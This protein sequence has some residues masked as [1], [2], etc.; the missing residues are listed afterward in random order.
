MSWVLADVDSTYDNLCRLHAVRDFLMYSASPSTTM[1]TFSSSRLFFASSSPRSD[2]SFVVDSSSIPSNS[3]GSSMWD[4][5]VGDLFNDAL[6]NAFPL[7]SARS[8]LQFLS[9][10]AEL[11][12]QHSAQQYVRNLIRARDT[13]LVTSESNPSGDI[14]TLSTLLRNVEISLIIISNCV[15]SS[16]W[17]PV[18]VMTRLASFDPRA[19]SLLLGDSSASSHCS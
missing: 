11:A 12:Q 14:F 16:S 8:P 4:R 13:V 18:H 9:E 6:G 17:S 10:S 5:Y 1:I 3:L 2:P 19:S 15:I 7:E